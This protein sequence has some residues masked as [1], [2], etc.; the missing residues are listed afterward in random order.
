[1]GRPREGGWRTAWLRWASLT[2]GPLRLAVLANEDTQQAKL[3]ARTID[4]WLLR[5]SRS[6][7]V[8]R[9]V[10]PP[11]AAKGGVFQA[12]LASSASGSQAMVGVSVGGAGTSEAALAEL[13]LAALGGADG[14]L[15]RALGS[16]PFGAS[17]SPRLVGGGATERW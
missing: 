13:M 6:P 16:A 17:A 11:A 5:P 9:A 2:A 10:D 8:C 15:T 4:C 3:A 12:N 14:Y 1:M 7:R